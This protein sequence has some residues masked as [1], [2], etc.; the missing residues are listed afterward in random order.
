MRKF[1]AILR[2]Y[3]VRSVTG[4][5]YGGNTFKLDFEAEGIRY[6]PS[7]L[8]KTELYEAFEPPL[9][10][11][12]IELPDIPKLQEQLLTLVIRSAH[13]DHQPGDHDD[14]ANAV[15]GAVYLILAPI[16][17]T[18]LSAF[19]SYSRDVPANQFGGYCGGG[20]NGGYTS[21][22]QDFWRYV[23]DIGEQK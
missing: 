9:N 18:G 13:V 16:Y 1:A 7:P 3:G 23:A 8:T 17:E 20:R 5:N 6:N 21:A 15:C 4:D 19:G 11:G 12:E 2:Q 14:H 22:P 10:A